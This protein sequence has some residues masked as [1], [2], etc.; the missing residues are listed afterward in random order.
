[1][2]IFVKP[3]SGKAINLEVEGSDTIIGIKA[4]VMAQ[5]Q[6]ISFDQEHLCFEG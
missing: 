1:M 6:D 2:W 4:K 5:L 3:S